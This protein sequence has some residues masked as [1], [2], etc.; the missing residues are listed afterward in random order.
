MPVGTRAATV[1]GPRLSKYSIRPRC[2]RIE[3][4]LSRSRRAGGLRPGTIREHKFRR[5]ATAGRS[6]ALPIIVASCSMCRHYRRLQMIELCLGRPERMAFMALRPKLRCSRCGNP[7]GNTCRY[8]SPRAAEPASAVSLM[9]TAAQQAR[10]RL[11]PKHRQ[12]P[13]PVAGTQGGSLLLRKGN[14]DNPS[15][16]H[17]ANDWPFDTASPYT[18]GL[19]QDSA[20]TTAGETRAA[21]GRPRRPIRGWPLPS[22]IGSPASAAVSRQL[23]AHP[24]LARSISPPTY[25]R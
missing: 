21:G 19:G 25:C 6:Q 15:R 18:L 3:T 2:N 8:R 5:P 1:T 13:R 9:G 7:N 20:H 4:G 16:P 23:A 14:P 10:R 24:G 22:P 12:L 11:H 17:A